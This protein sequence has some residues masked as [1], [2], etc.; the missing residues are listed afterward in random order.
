MFLNYFGNCWFV[1][2][3]GEFVF[4]KEIVFFIGIIVFKIIYVNIS[5]IFFVFMIRKKKRMSI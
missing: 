3:V 4:R 1:K 2:L 5:M